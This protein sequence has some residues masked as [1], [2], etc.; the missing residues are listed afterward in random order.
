VK[1]EP[2]DTRTPVTDVQEKANGYLRKIRTS[3]TYQAKTPQELID[4]AK[5][6]EPAQQ[7][8]LYLAAAESAAAQGD[9]QGVIHAYAR[10]R[11]NFASED[12]FLAQESEDVKTCSKRA[13]DPAGFSPVAQGLMLRHCQNGNFAG[14]LDLAGTL[15]KKPS[16]T[17]TF[18]KSTGEILKLQRAYEEV[19]PHFDTLRE[20]PDDREANQAVGFYLLDAGDFDRALAHLAK[21]D[22]EVR[23]LAAATRQRG[24]RNPEETVALARRWKTVR[25]DALSS[26]GVVK[27]ISILYGEAGKRASGVAR[28]AIQ[29][30]ATMFTGRH[31]S[32]VPDLLR[33][34]VQ[35]E[36]AESKTDLMRQLTKLTDQEWEARFPKS[37]VSREWMSVDGVRRCI[38]HFRKGAT[39]TFPELKNV[40]SIT[41]VFVQT[42]GTQR[43][44]ITVNHPLNGERSVSLV[45]DGFRGSTVAYS[46]V[47]GGLSDNT[48]L[49]PT[50][51]K[52]PIIQNARYTLTMERE[53]QA[54][55]GG[56]EPKVKL[57][58]FLTPF[59][60]QTVPCTSYT[61]PLSSLWCD[62]TVQEAKDC[63]A[64]HTQTD[65]YVLEVHIV[66]EEEKKE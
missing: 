16:F 36:G 55:P 33:G 35:V 57:S 30:E 43:E 27:L 2:K 53:L 60:G 14:A 15:R 45:I 54:D 38:L 41:V 24:E 21:G 8:S 7:Y 10:L 20:R 49:N 31:G 62:R 17:R 39:L 34:E 19:Q 61:G 11:T 64:L 46:R 50:I 48:K 63:F 40:K 5:S 12:D 28:T 18:G 6:L 47:N 22:E 3:A 1:E 66:P 42:P 59:K 29:E 51:R 4:E 65:Y 44:A 52:S 23:A 32:R 26:G 56:G 37:G 58:S 13:R 25:P 9:I